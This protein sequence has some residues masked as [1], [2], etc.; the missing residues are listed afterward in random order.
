VFPFSVCSQGR[1]YK[2]DIIQD[3]LTDFQHL[4]LTPGASHRRT[5]ALGMNHLGLALSM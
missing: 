4:S 1:R 2:K 5:H 3:V